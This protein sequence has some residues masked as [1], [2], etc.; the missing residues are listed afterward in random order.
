MTSTLESP[1]MVTDGTKPSA[2][3]RFDLRALISSTILGTAFGLGVPLLAVQLGMPSL[4][5]G[6]FAGALTGAAVY[7]FYLVQSKTKRPKT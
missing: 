1:E 3:P 6:P 4:L 2:A 7:G 5:A